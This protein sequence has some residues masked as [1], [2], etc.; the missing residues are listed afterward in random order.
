MYFY[1]VA[2][3]PDI[4]YCYLD[5]SA[6]V[7][8]YVTEPGSTWTQHLLENRDLLLST[9]EIALVEVSTAL[10]IQ[11][12][13]GRLSHRLGRLA[14]AV[15]QEHVVNN[16]YNMIPADRVI[17]DKAAALGRK[18][19]LKAYD[20]IHVATALHLRDLLKIRDRSLVFVCADSQALRA[21]TAESLLTENPHD[22][23]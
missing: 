21:A 17:I 11:V 3:N 6:L 12:R 14:Y 15:F 23:F 8:R 7:K 18:H 5:T 13:T 9:S 20:A 16:E 1:H 22:H 10:S 4:Q 2:S 19:P